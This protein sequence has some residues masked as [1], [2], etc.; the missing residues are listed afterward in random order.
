[1]RIL[2]ILKNNSV[3]RKPLLYLYHKLHNRHLVK[4]WYSSDFSYRCK[5]EGMNKI[6]RNSCFF[7][8]LG[9]GSII[10]DNCLISADVGKFCSLSHQFTYTNGTHPMHSPYVTTS[11]FFYSLNKANSPTG[12]VFAQKQ[13]MKEEFRYYDKKNELVNKIGNDVWVG[14][15]VNIIGGVQIGDGAVVLSRAVVTKDVPPYAIVGGVPARVL[16]YRY[17]KDTIDFLLRIQWW[18]NEPSWFK[19]NWHL[20]NDIDKL[21]EYYSNE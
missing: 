21:K 11:A 14:I 2:N 10:G 8:K 18:N 16:K 19:E 20:L 15:D 5:F 17:D 6:G 4:F 13:V 12:E 9:Y 7:G 1:M 3:I